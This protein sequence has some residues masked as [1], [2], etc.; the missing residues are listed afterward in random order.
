[1]EIIDKIV[2]PGERLSTEEEF[3]TSDN[4]FIEE[5][6]IYSSSTGKVDVK[7]G[8]ISVISPKEA[9]PFKKGMLILGKITDDLRSV[10]F[11]KIENQ[12]KGSV[13]YK[14][15]K[16]GKIINK[17][18]MET[19]KPFEIG[20]I[21][22]ARIIDEDKGIYELNTYEPEC[23]VVYSKCH[24]CNIP[25]SYDKEYNVLSCDICHIKKH[26]KISTLYNDMKAIEEKLLND[27]P[28][29]HERRRRFNRAEEGHGRQ[30]RYER[31]EGG[32]QYHRN[33]R[34]RD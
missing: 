30:G 5:G 20:D 19:D 17:H 22:L 16:N 11:V 2:I 12:D 1:M 14:A 10:L 32:R 15:L 21:I 28:E 34:Y 18:S 8:K 6:G 26:K 33:T 9:R 23:G 13:S 24:S 29:E 4:T 27:K 25:L 7:G 3:T 31:H